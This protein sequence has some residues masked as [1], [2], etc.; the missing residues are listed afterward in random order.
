MILHQLAIGAGAIAVSVIIHAS[1]MLAAA[2]MPKR[3]LPPRRGL[4]RKGLV[5]IAVVLWFFLSIC[6]Q[7]WV[8]A[9]LLLSLGA[10]GSLEAALYF[11]TVTFTTLGYGDIVLGEDWRLLGAFAA[12][13]GTIIIGWTTAMVFLAVQRVYEIHAR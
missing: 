12:A 13:N 1:F 6:V 4:L 3:E 7:C 2:A 10:L 11:S 9:M 8:W 5:I